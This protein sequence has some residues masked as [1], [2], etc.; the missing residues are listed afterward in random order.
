MPAVHLRPAAF[1]QPPPMRLHTPT[2]A[3]DQFFTRWQNATLSERA[4]YQQHFADVCHLLGAQTPIE[5]DNTGEDYTYE[6][7]LKKTDGRQGYADV[8]YRNHFAIEYKGK[9]KYASLNE[10]Y[11]QL[12]QYRENLNNPPL[13]IVCDIEHWEIHTNFTNAPA[14]VHRFT[15]TD[16][17][18]KPEKRAL[19]RRAFTD[20]ASFHP[21][22]NKNQI[23]EEV[24]GQFRY[25]VDD[26]LEWQNQPER[27][28][29]FLTKLMFCMFVEDIGLLPKRA[30][31]GIFTEI[32]RTT[33]HLA[34]SKTLFAQYV[35]ELFRAMATGGNVQMVDIPYFNG[36]MF[37]A[38][39]DEIVSTLR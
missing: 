3:P 28:A 10:A 18:A 33:R 24:A 22:Q 34:N 30:Y 37:E 8:F 9:G 32:V 5:V 4:S 26:T 19:L 39:E 14:V 17:L 21:E 35:G 27:V 23:T 2:L 25:V 29:R 16:V 15:H 20:P 38:G 31:N 11:R 6:Y 13:L 1:P 7:G 12:Q 36:S